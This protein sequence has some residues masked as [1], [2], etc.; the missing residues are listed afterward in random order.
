MS[1]RLEPAT[2]EDVPT[3]VTIFDEAFAQDAI[4]H[5]IFKDVPKEV[6]W[7]RDLKWYSAAFENSESNG[8]RF[9]KVVDTSNGYHRRF[10]RAYTPCSFPQS[11]DLL[12][13]V[14]MML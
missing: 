10:S 6:R 2:I 3:L 11:S 1:F 14:L 9:T 12:I 13:M 5:H 4:F 7:E 8:A